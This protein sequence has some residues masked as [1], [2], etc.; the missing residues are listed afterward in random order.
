MTLLDHTSYRIRADRLRTL[1]AKVGLSQTALAAVAGYSSRLI[2]KAESVGRLS[3]AAIED[4]VQALRER[5]ADVQTG[6]L[7][8]DELLTC[9]RFMESFE[10]HAAAVLHHCAELLADNFTFR[11]AGNS[12]HPLFVAET[13]KE[14][15]QVWLDRFFGLFTRDPGHPLSPRYLVADHGVTARFDEILIRC[16]QTS[17]RI[18]VNFH[19]EIRGGLI[20]RLENQYDTQ[21]MI[22]FLNDDSLKDSATQ[23]RQPFRHI[24]HESIIRVDQILP[25]RID[26]A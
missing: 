11:S 21:A 2:R 4:I 12:C 6:D 3:G 14:G 7:L 20:H 15:F 9:K 18:W 13:G 19:F 24:V 1:R 5:G 16:G 22:D 8:F 10:K 23:L 25:V 17:P 26:G